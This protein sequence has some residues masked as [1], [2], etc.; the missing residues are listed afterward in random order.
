MEHSDKQMRPNLHKRAL[1]GQ[2][3]R[4]FSLDPFLNCLEVARQPRLILPFEPGTVQRHMWQ[5]RLLGILDGELCSVAEEERKPRSGELHGFVYRCFAG[6][7]GLQTGAG[8]LKP[9]ISAFLHVAELMVT[10]A[11]LPSDSCVIVVPGEFAVEEARSQ[12]KQLFVDSIELHQ[13]IAASLAVKASPSMRVSGCSVEVGAENA[14]RAG[15]T[16]PV[17]LDERN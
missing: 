11:H 2:R 12:D 8:N 10:R 6:Q 7:D 13:V 3:M 15:K 1:E 9:L 16:A 14:R 5:I 17:V 4:T